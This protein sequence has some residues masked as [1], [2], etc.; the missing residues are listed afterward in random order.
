MTSKHYKAIQRLLHLVEPNYVSVETNYVYERGEIDLLGRYPNG[1][2]DFYEV[3][4]D[5][6][7][8]NLRKGV[9][10]LRRA[11]KH[12]DLRGKDFIFTPDLGINDLETV[13]R[14]LSA[15]NKKKRR[16]R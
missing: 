6:A 5:S 2:V 12:L 14:H 7:P 3:K 10:Q 9:A 11:R 4:S 8:H 1:T 16:F 15:L 13:T